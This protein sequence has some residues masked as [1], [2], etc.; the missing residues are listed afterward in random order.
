MK[1]DGSEGM[2]GRHGHKIIVEK[3]MMN[4]LRA[5]DMRSLWDSGDRNERTDEG[6]KRN[7]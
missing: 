2:K 7:G 5:K 1:K 3:V 6:K 4:I